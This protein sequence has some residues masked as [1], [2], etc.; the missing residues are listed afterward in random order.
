ML[1]LDYATNFRSITGSCECGMVGHQVESLLHSLLESP[2]KD[3]SEHSGESDQSLH[4][5]QWY[6]IQCL[7]MTHRPGAS[8]SAGLTCLAIESESN[9]SSIPFSMQR[10]K[11]ILSGFCFWGSP[12]SSSLSEGIHFRTSYKILWYPGMVWTVVVSW[13]GSWYWTMKVI[14]SA[15]NPRYNSRTTT[16]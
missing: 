13:D 8:T 9:T 16:S 1:H 3:P 14:C 15:Y 10:M 12:K 7:P 2:G 6:Q 11:L 4:C 5:Q